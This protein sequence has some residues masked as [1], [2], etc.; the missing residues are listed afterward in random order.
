M[1]EWTPS[2]NISLSHLKPLFT[3]WCGLD[4][5]LLH[6]CQAIS[7][8]SSANILAHCSKW[9]SLQ[10]I[11]CAAVLLAL[12]HAQKMLTL[13]GSHGLLLGCGA[14]LDGTAC[15]LTK[16]RIP[17]SGQ[18]QHCTSDTSFNTL[19]TVLLVLEQ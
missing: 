10:R 11:R 14:Y 13:L 18:S 1:S 15:G 12:L 16:T 19:R 17:T 6:S 8:T 7:S 9:A 3:T 4:M 5:C 2:L